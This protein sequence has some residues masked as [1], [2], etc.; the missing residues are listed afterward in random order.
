MTIVVLDSKSLKMKEELDKMA[1][2]ATRELLQTNEKPD[3]PST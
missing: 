2:R 3:V 1:L